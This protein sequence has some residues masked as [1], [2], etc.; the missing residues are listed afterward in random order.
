MYFE[1]KW[2]IFT[3]KLL[4]ALIVVLKRIFYLNVHVL[5]LCTCYLK[6][7]YLILLPLVLT[8]HDPGYDLER[9]WTPSGPSCLVSVD[10]TTETNAHLYKSFVCY[11]LI[12]GWH[13]RQYSTN[14]TCSMCDITLN[15]VFLNSFRP[16]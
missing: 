16:T 13:I 7:S 2:I 11:L 1:V 6:S 12:G 10:G 5:V 4:K 14:E 15:I 8:Q 3:L 9:K